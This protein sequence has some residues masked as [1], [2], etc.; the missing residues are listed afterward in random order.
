[1]Y[2]GTPIPH[3]TKENVFA[4]NGFGYTPLALTLPKRLGRF[5]YSNPLSRAVRTREG[6]DVILRVI[7]IGQEGHE[8]LQI[9]RKLATGALSLCSENH[10]LPMF[11][12]LQFEDIIFGVF[13][14]AGGC[15]VDALGAWP[16]N[17]T[18]DLVD[19]LLQM[20]EDAFSD[21]FVVQWHP[22]SLAAKKISISRP[23]VYL[24]DFEVAI[25]F[26]EDCP[27]DKRVCVGPPVGGSFSSP[28]MYNR[29]CPPEVKSGG[30]YDPFKLDVW[31]LASSLSKF[32]SK[33]PAIDD[34]LIAMSDDDPVLRLG[35]QQALD[36]LSQVVASMPPE[37]LLFEPEGA[38]KFG[39][40]S[41]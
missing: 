2:S 9:L 37:L 39:S 31:Q 19:M 4:N 15:V 21:N 5:E 1:M 7:V 20:L 16:R 33:I 36:R 26:P 8:N 13:P 38:F 27:I 17:S 24:I 10:T 22:E 32:K 25:E 14:K 35:A 34:V 29:Q 23:R 3:A 40:N 12:E 28:D 18:G 6:H 11:A 30:P 41:N